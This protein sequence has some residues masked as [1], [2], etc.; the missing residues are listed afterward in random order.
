MSLKEKRHF[1][2]FL[3]FWNM[4]YYSWTIMPMK[5]VNDSRAQPEGIA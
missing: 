3:I 5:N 4:S 2:F 1:A